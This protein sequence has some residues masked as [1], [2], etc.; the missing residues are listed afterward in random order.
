MRDEYKPDAIFLW[1]SAIMYGCL[2]ILF[3]INPAGL[4]S[5]LG[6]EN[7][8]SAGL[9]DVMATYGGLEIGIAISII[10]CLHRGQYQLGH[11]IVFYTFGGFALGRLLGAVRFDGFQGMHLYWFLIEVFYLAVTYLFI[12]KNRKSIKE[13][14][15]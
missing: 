9:T 14:P 6:Y 13:V 15:A 2:G 10:C 4:A 8:T 3:L 7:L 1:I 5:G 11:W 12:R